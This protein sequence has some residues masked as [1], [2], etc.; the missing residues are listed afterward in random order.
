MNLTG[1]RFAMD[2][3]MKKK[4][5]MKGKYEQKR[6]EEVDIGSIHLFVEQAL[7]DKEEKGDCLG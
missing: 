5:R 1:Q 6:E 2:S 4:K 7:Y 3:R